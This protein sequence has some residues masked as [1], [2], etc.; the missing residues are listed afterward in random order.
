MTPDEED[1]EER[2]AIVADGNRITQAEAERIVRQWQQD[3]Q[4]LPLVT[5]ANH[6]IR[7]AYDCVVYYLLEVERWRDGG[8]T[9]RT[10][11]TLN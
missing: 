11:P 8:E 4:R 6:M 2:I 1:F 7:Q 3:R 5:P 10:Y 9:T